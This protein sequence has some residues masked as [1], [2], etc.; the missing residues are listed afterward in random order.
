MKISYN[1]IKKYLPYIGSPEEVADLLVM[2]TAEVEEIHLE[3]E[4]LKGVYIWFI[5]EYKKHP[6]SE[7]LGICQVEI[8]GET[9]QIVCW[10]PNARA[11]LK[12]AVA[13]IWTELAA[14]FV[15]AKTKIRGEVSEWMI[16]S[17]DELGLISE[18]QAG[19]ME[20][21]ED[22]PLWMSMR[23]YLWKNDAVLEIDNKA[24][25][26]RP[27]MFSHI[28]VMREI[29][30]LYSKELPLKYEDVDFTGNKKYEIKNEIPHLVKRYIALSLSNVENSH[31]PES[32]KKFIEA[33]WNTSKWIL[34]DI[35]N[36]SLSFYGQPTHCFDR[37]KI[38]WNITVRFAKENEEFIALDGKSYTLSCQ[39]IVIADDEKILALWWIIGWKSSS[40][41]E[42]TKN[43]IVEAAN[44]PWEILRH[45]GRRL[46]IRTDALNIFEKNIPAHFAQNGA[47]LIYTTLKEI[48]P[49]LEIESYG[50]IYSKKDDEITIAYD[51]KFIS[52]LTWRNYSKEEINSILHL[53]WIEN[54]WSTLKMPF[55]RVDM[56]YKAD[57]AEEIA[58]IHGYEN[59]E[60]T[61]PRINL[62]AIKQESIYHL[63]KD[64]RNF[65]TSI[66]FFEMY[67][68]SFVNKELLEKLNLGVETSIEMKNALSEEMTHLR[69]SLI[70]NL[71]LSLEKNIRDQKDLKLVELEKI[72][73]KKWTELS[74]NYSLA[75]VIVSKSDVPY[76][77]LQ[78]ILTNFFKTISIDRFEYK[79]NSIFPAYAH[80]GRTASIMVRWQEIWYIWEI[81]PLVSQRFDV[82][83][84]IAF[85]ELN[86]DKL[87]TFGYNTKKAKEISNFQE[88]NFDLSFVI[89]KTKA[90]KDVERAITKTNPII[91]KVE[92][93]DIYENEEKIPGKRSLSFTIYIQSNEGTLDDTVKN[94]II[95]EIIKNVEKIGGTLRN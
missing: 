52:N 37:D 21:P 51:E 2:H 70:P 83:D 10:A 94:N 80:K 68:Y 50:E 3:W 19:I 30:T 79:K 86:A 35:T 43:I 29:A 23:E 71:V 41:S 18:R 33:V 34:V 5:K 54:N 65:F 4:N 22:A 84:R 16:C 91:Q 72:F 69:N 28:G 57:I 27:D 87:A 55:W 90:W 48:F 20:L 42:T 95:N 59:I 62:W 60:S 6:D 39:D 61:V 1:L 73:H 36:Y 56:R 93:F 38:K 12:V 31:S 53:L 63:K 74:E 44:F 78:W 64:S 47:S 67:N 9:K 17:L 88:N 25:N 24:I 14:D 49:H 11:S 13:T 45:T 82:T 75:G 8:L 15:I 58:R 85:F 26:H 7:K 92:L 76:Y 77:E 40:V 81:H 89:D 46:W 66:W 32:I